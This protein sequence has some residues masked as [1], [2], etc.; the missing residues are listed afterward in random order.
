MPRRTKATPAPEPEELEDELDDLEEDDVEEEE[1]EPVKKAPVRRTRKTAVKKV[2]PVVD[3]DDDELEDDEEEKPAK[4]TPPKR[5][6]IEFG[7]AWLANLANDK[8]GTNYTPYTLRA[9]IRKLIKDGVYDRAVG[10]DRS[11]Y[12]FSGPKDPAVAAIL[13][14]LKSMP[15]KS[16]GNRSDNLKKA[17]EVK[18]ARAAARKAEIEDDDEIEE[19]DD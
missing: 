6:P 17:R 11:R 5:E 10:E 2:A 12:E 19:L 7:T 13:K 15:E 3:D 9:A 16:T 18:A 14:A 8:L 4:R 1:P